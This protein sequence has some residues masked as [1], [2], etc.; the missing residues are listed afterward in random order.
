MSDQ[1]NKQAKQDLPA[2][3]AERPKPAPKPSPEKRPEKQAPPS[4]N[5]SVSKQE[6]QKPKTGCCREGIGRS[7]QR[8]A[9]KNKGL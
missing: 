3:P 2:D 1:E 8:E 5:Y 4:K 7:K 9:R 6:S